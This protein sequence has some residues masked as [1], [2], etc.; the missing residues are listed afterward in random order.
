MSDPNVRQVK[1]TAEDIDAVSQKLES[2]AKGLPPG[3]Q[4]VL[5]WLLGRAASAGAQSTNAD[6]AELV[7]AAEPA[8]RAQLDD[9]LGIAQF[10]QLKPGSAFAGSTIGVTGTVMF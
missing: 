9:S 2:F 1:V 8:F 5:Q 10:D 3:E 7:P 4:N 6:P